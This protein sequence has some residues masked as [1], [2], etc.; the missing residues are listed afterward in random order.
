MTQDWAEIQKAIYCDKGYGETKRALTQER[1]IK[2]LAMLPIHSRV[3]DLGCN[4]GSFTQVLQEKG[5]EV[6]GVDFGEV[7]QMARKEHPNC[8]FIAADIEDLDFPE[9]SFDAVI[10]LGLIEHLV[11]D[12]ELLKKA[13]RWLALNGQIFLSTPLSPEKI[14][15]EDSAHIRFYPPY[16][17]LRLLEV[18][19]FKI[20]RIDIFRKVD[21]Y[22]IIGEKAGEKSG[23]L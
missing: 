10:A 23:N 17:L 9:K 21:E 15:E 19:G 8:D 22:L 12:I 2:T 4:D 14:C 16:S 20:S 18:C 7:I 5:F 13:Y 3:L 6:S 1:F 11:R